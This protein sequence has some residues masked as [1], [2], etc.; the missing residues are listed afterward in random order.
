MSSVEV[1]HGTIQYG[2]YINDTWHGFKDVY[3]TQVQDN[4]RIIKSKPELFDGLELY[5]TGGILEGWLTWDLDWTI[6]GPYQPEKIKAAM[7]WITQVGF[8]LGIYPDVTYTEELFDLHEWQQTRQCDDRWLYRYSDLFIKEGQ[9]TID[10]SNY[11]LA[12]AGL[13]KFWA[14]CPFPKNIEMD[15]QG[16]RYKKPLKV[17]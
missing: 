10:M 4:I 11:I 15:Q 9:K 13:Y 12:E 1:W 2:D 14:E 3:H 17:L 16:H 7:D 6:V 5:L 8:E